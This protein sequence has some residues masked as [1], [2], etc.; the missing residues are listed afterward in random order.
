[1][2]DISDSNGNGKRDELSAAEKNAKSDDGT[3]S[4]DKK[5]LNVRISTE[6]YNKLDAS[7]ESKGA[8][9]T[10]AL[11]KYLS[12]DT[13]DAVSQEYVSALLKQL[14]IKDAQISALN[15]QLETKDE[16]ITERDNTTK[17]HIAQV[18]TLINQVEKKTL[19]L[20]DAKKKKWYQFW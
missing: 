11:E 13:D 20:E 7:G 10:K 15:R 18:Q 1:M 12:D 3:K 9:V 8:A 4:D 14:E 19:E 16:Q 5:Q 2:I 17:M 6:L